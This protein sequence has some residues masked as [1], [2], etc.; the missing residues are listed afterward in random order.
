M[1]DYKAIW[2]KLASE[3]KITSADVVA[4]SALLAMESKN[5]TDRRDVIRHIL[6]KNFKSTPKRDTPYRALI[7]AVRDLW[8]DLNAGLWNSAILQTNILNI[9]DSTEEFI[10]FKS[11]IHSIEPYDF[12]R[13][14]TYIFVRK[15]LEPIYQLVQ[16]S[17]AAMCAGQKLDPKF[18]PHNIYFSVVGV[19]DLYDLMLAEEKL[20]ELGFEYSVFVEPDNGNEATAIATQP[21]HWKKRKPLKKY[22]LLSFYSGEK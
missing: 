1:R 15:D 18:N 17:H 21:I 7:N 22:P 4:Y 14:Y 11:L 3:K 19:D 16:A 8:R 13:V 20:N 5:P 10:E 9:F 12:D 6:L 2:K